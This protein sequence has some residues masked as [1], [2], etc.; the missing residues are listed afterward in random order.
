MQLTP[1]DIK[2]LAGLQYEPGFIV[3]LD[4][5][6]AKLDTLTDELANPDLTPE[7]G[8]SKLRYWQAFREILHSIRT[9]PKSFEEVLRE[10]P[11]S[12]VDN[13]LSNDWMTAARARLS[14][15]IL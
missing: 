11:F 12:E 4:Y 8:A 6:Q 1:Q 3:L 10:N 2:L 14:Q 15:P 13:V 5:L 7:E 9:T